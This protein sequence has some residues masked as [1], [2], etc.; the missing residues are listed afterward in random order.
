MLQSINRVDITVG[1]KVLRAKRLHHNDWIANVYGKAKILT[2][3]E[4]ELLMKANIENRTIDTGVKDVS[5]QISPKT[6]KLEAI[7][8]ILV[9]ELFKLQDH[10]KITINTLDPSDLASMTDSLIGLLH[11]ATINTEVD[12][13]TRKLLNAKGGTKQ[14]TKI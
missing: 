4:I 14:T 3:G 12:A 2:T 9:Q 13:K 11:S 6:A 1:D 7:K 10:G 5:H 8:S